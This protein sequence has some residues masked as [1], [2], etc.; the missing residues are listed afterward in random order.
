MYIAFTSIVKMITIGLE[1]VPFHD[2]VLLIM[3]GFM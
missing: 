1:Y 2:T 3:G